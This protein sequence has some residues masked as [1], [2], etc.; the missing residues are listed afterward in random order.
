MLT[1]ESRHRDFPTLA[2]QT[3]L[4]TAAEGLPPPAVLRA[5][6]DYLRDKQDGM[7]GRDAHFSRLEACRLAA[8]A[9]VGMQPTEVAF[10]S[11]SSE[12][13]NLLASALNLTATDEVV[14]SD[15]DFPAGV[16]PWL[17]GSTACTPRLWQARSGRL[18]VAALERLLSAKT[19]LVQ[20]SLISF[21]NGHHLAWD[22][23]R[24]AV[25]RLAPQALLAVDVTQALGRVPRLCPGADVIISSTHKWLL[26]LHG[27]CIVGIRD[28][29]ADQLTPRAGGWHHLENAFATDRFTRA[30]VCRGAAG[31]AVGMPNFPAI[32]GL[33]AALGYLRE[34]GVEAIAKH[35]DP[36]VARA[37]A[38]LEDLGFDLLC[39]LEAVLPGGIIAFQHPDSHNLADVLDRAAIHVMHHAGRIRIAVHGYNTQD[40][41]DRML[42]AMRGHQDRALRSPED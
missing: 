29:V 5:V 22:A 35:A 16:T 7:R 3:Y 1:A 39:P 33:E 38:G 8:A 13:Y 37:A 42:E 41:I 2:Q 34:T 20:V 12:A 19:R 17:T 30:V 28:G 9:A 40:D 11:C 14:F 26:G 32:Y 31:Y 4:N 23:T 15:L 27:G 25:R 6:A 24:D 36:L 10:C 18:E 21:W